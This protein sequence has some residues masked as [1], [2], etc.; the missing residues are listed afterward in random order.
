MKFDPEQ[1]IITVPVDIRGITG[2]LNVTMALDT[3]ASYTLMPWVVAEKL[4]Y[5]PASSRKRVNIITVSGV[6]RAPLVVVE[7]MSVLGAVVKGAEVVIHDMPEG[8]RIDGLLGLNFLRG[9]IL[10]I[11][12]KEGLLEITEK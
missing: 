7:E 9:K 5:D 8:S 2:W 11:D 12:L 10:K 6:E 4:G 3:G 1:S